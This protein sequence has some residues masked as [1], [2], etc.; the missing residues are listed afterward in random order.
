MKILKYDF[1]LMNRKGVG[2]RKWKWYGIA[3]SH[4]IYFAADI[5][6]M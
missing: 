3:G 6:G 2:M 4:R 1:V 5:Y